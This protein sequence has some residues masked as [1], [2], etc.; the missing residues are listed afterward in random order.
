MKSY[1]PKE[2]EK[3]RLEKHKIVQ[4]FIDLVKKEYSEEAG[5]KNAYNIMISL[6]E[7]CFYHL[8]Y[9]ERFKHILYHAFLG[10]PLAEEKD[11]FIW[12]EVDDR[13]EK[14]LLDRIKNYNNK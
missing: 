4:T 7:E 1:T 12:D 13:A 3:V 8:D 6:M 11:K 14:I 5:P 9:E 2:A 10:S